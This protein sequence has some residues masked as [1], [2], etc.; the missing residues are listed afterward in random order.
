MKRRY[1]LESDVSEVRFPMTMDKIL[2]MNTRLQENSFTS[3]AEA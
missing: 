3:F 2:R 1:D